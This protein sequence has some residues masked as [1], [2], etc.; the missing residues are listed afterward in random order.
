MKLPHRRQ[1]LR[2]A[3]SAATLPVLSR[4]AGAQAYPSRPVRIVVPF[5]PGGPT[6]VFARV[7]GQRLTEQ[8]GKQFFVEN[9][10]GA[11]GN[12]GT[13][14]VARSAPDGYTILITVNS[15]VINPTFYH[16]ISYDPYKSFDPVTLAATFALCILVNPSVPAR[17]FNDLIALIKVNPGKY[18]YA[19]TGTGTSAHIQVEQLRLSASLDLVA[20]PFSGGGP[21]V[22]ATVAGHTPITCAALAP[23]MPHITEGKL[24]AL[25]I[26]TRSR[27][28]PD[29]P[30]LAEAGYPEIGKDDWVGVFVPART[31]KEIV[32]ALNRSIATII[33]S[34]DAIERMATLGFEPLASTPEEFGARI[35]VEIDTW[36]KM[37]RATNIKAE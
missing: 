3:A 26:T 19:S 22:A 9:I 35:G 18:S 16:R 31:P 21:A 25:A 27:L 15:Y 17:T 24:R 14:Q 10:V 20:V 36:G 13:G 5:G 28:L 6:D 1:F 30:S 32:I 7:I 2:L 29:V 4:A 33:A 12:I 11:G 23:A 8:F 37:I 34:T